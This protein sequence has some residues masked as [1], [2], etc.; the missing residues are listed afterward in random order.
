MTLSLPPRAMNLSIAGNMRFKPEFRMKETRR[1]IRSAVS[2]SSSSSLPS[3]GL[4]VAPVK[5]LEK[6]SGTEGR[7]AW[8]EQLLF[9]RFEE[10]RIL[11]GIEFFDLRAER[12]SE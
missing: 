3:C 6:A 1:S 5:R 11:C 9:E 7:G 10:G 12:L 2:N 8:S 4:P